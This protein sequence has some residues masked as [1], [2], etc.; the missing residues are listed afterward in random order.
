MESLPTTTSQTT[1]RARLEATA[2]ASACVVVFVDVMGQYFSTPVLIPYAMSLE[3]DS[4][5][6]GCVMGLPFFG[7]IIGGVFM[8]VLADRVSRKWTMWL[9]TLGSAIAYGL[10]AWAATMGLS[11]L[12][13]GR[14]IGG[15][16]GQ[17]LALVMAYLADL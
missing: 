17:T 9:S 16:F 13:A 8:P 7:R 14:L 1:V 3:A 12:V 11:V 10:S 5:M 15:I 2:F 6:Q 4:F